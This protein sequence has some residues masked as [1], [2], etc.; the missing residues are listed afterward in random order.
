VSCSERRA[1]AAVELAADVG[2]IE[3]AV[4]GFAA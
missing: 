2:A 1:R 3:I 4:E